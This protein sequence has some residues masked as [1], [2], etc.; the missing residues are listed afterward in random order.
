MARVT[1]AAYN[2]PRVVAR[3]N[4]AAAE[5]RWVKKIAPRGSRNE[6][7]FLS[8]VSLK[9]FLPEGTR[10]ATR[11]EM[12]PRHSFGRLALFAAT[13]RAAADIFQAD[14][15]APRARRGM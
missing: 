9:S 11:D 2:V 3:A 10:L 12:L 5:G 15:S 1:T 8:N 7:T 14:S 4:A 6:S 13:H